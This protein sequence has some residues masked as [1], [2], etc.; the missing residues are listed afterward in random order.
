VVN[1]ILVLQIGGIVFGITVIILMQ[2]ISGRIAS[3]SS[4][5]F[6]GLLVAAIVLSVFTA[7]I[8]GAAAS[9]EDKS[10]Q[11]VWISLLWMVIALI[12]VAILAPPTI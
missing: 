7:V 2:M 10:C 4:S 1:K 5:S 11:Q 6:Y 12:N 3:S 8:Y 9:L